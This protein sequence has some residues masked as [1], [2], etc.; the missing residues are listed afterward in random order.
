MKEGV[1]WIIP[2]FSLLSMKINVVQSLNSVG[3]SYIDEFFCIDKIVDVSMSGELLAN[4][5]EFCRHKYYF[6]NTISY[7]D[8]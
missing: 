6:A 1:K 5:N 2:I 4:E 8:I 3:I 7:V